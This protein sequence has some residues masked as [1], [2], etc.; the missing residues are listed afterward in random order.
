MAIADALDLLIC[1]KEQTPDLVASEISDQIGTAYSR[2]RVQNVLNNFTAVTH[3]DSHQ[4]ENW[5]HL[6]IAYRII[7]AKFI[8]IL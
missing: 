8:R 5:H 4:F 6:V 2:Q 1:F 3:Y 7:R